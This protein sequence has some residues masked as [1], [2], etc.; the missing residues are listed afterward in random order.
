MKILYKSRNAVV[1][2]K[3][4]GISSQPDDLCDGDAMT[5]LSEQ[6][7]T[8]GEP[9]ILYPVHR[10]DKVVGGLLIFARNKQSAAKLSAL[11]SGEGIGKE[12]FAVADG[13]AIGGEYTDMLFKDSRQNK[14]IIS[15]DSQG[16]AKEARLHATAI[17][18][19]MTDKGAKT[20]LRIKLDTGRFHQIRAQLS[21]R[22]TPIT[23]DSKYGSRDYRCRIPALHSS[24]LTLTLGA[25]KIDVFCPP[26]TDAYPWNLFSADKYI[27]KSAKEV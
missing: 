15:K 25:E 27:L 23:G 4:P 14:A 17:D 11:I 13:E 26:D 6:L 10:L 16:G 3:P 12:Y 5:E 21:S 2:Y 22:K 24:R 9:D 18:T 8:L 19:V 20:L 1:I 7:G